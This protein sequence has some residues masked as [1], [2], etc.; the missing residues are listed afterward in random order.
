[1][2]GGFFGGG[3]A[4]G[5]HYGVA[6]T[7]VATEGVIRIAGRLLYR[8]PIGDVVRC[9]LLAVGEATIRCSNCTVIAIRQKALS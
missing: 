1:M 8:T 3:G 2:P 4:S 7:I 6:V 5:L 9:A